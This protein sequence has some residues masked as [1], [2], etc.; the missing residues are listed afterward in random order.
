MLASKARIEQ[1]LIGWAQGQRKMIICGHTHHPTSAQYGMTPYFNTGSCV[2]PNQITGLEIRDGT[3]A[4]VRWTVK[5]GRARRE[6][7]TQPRQLRRYS[8]D[9]AR[10]SAMTSIPSRH[11]A[12]EPASR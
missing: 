10:N 9:D 2:E 5:R 11:C 4:E 12:S 7:V 3:I 6:S 1:R 8:R